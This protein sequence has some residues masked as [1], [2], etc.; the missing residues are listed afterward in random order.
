M[1]RKRTLITWWWLLV[2]QFY[3]FGS[4]SKSRPTYCDSMNCSTSGFPVLHHLL[5]IAQTHV[6]WDGDAIQPS[7]PLWPPFPPTFNL[8][9]RV[10]SSESA[11]HIRWLKYWSFSISPFKEYSGSISFRIDWF[12][13]LDV[14]KTLKCITQHHN[15][16]TS[17]LWHSGFFMVQVS[18]PYMTTGKTIALTRWTFVSKVMSLFFKMLSRLVIVFHPRS[19]PVLVSWL[20]SL[21]TVIL[22]PKKIKSVNAFTFSPSICHEMMG[23]DAMISVFWMFSFKPAFSLLLLFSPLSPLLRG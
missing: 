2:L 18:H 14:Q 5:E 19:K 12:D 8:S 15:S 23:L 21:S 16:K 20:Q 13:V 17:I 4:V 3:C 6:H 10:F 7:R 9:M 11:L 22:E 1:V